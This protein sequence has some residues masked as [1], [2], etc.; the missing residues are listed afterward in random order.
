LKDILGLLISLIIVNSCNNHENNYLYSAGIKNYLND[1]LKIDIDKVDNSIMY[2]LPINECITCSGTSLEIDMLY[3]IPQQKNFKLIIIGL[4]KYSRFFNRINSIS[5]QTYFDNKLD[6]TRY[7]TG[8]SKPLL[9]HIRN[10]KI[11]YFLKVSDQLIDKAKK[12]II[13]N[14]TK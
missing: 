9:I 13:Q 1:I 3:Q 10:G 7:P 14:A 12:Y 2:F 6:I 5:Q 11:D 4:D 8:V